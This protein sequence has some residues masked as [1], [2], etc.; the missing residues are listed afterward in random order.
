[1]LVAL[2]RSGVR[3]PV[4]VPVGPADCDRLRARWA[5]HAAAR[6]AAVAALIAERTGD[7]ALQTRVRDR[8]APLLTRGVG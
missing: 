1:M 5:K 8:L 2:I 7:E 3:G 6:E 4:R